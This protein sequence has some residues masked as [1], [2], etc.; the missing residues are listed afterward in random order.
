MRLNEPITNQQ[1]LKWGISRDTKIGDTIYVLG[2]PFGIDAISISDGIIRDNK[3]VYANIIESI[4]ISAP[5][6]GG[7]SGSAV[8]DTQGR[9]IG[10]ISYGLRSSDTI[11]WGASQYVLEPIVN[12]IIET[13]SNYIG[14]SIESTIYPVDALYLRNATLPANLEGY[15]VSST[16]NGSFTVD[17]VI[18]SIEGNVLGLYNNQ[19][20]PIDIYTN[21]GNNLSMDING[22]VSSIAITPLSLADDIH[23]GG[24]NTIKPIKKTPVGSK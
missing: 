14:G 11:S 10:I 20:T 4:S 2:D 17:D 7:N 9:V 22:T 24:G 15:Y 6:Y 3:Y 12:Q 21:S 16:T 19:H 5:I 1:F 8:L 23:L 18:V 13:S